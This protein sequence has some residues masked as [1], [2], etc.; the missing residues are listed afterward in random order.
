MLPFEKQVDPGRFRF[1]TV[2]SV[3]Y[4]Y[5]CRDVSPGDPC[6]LDRERSLRV[7]VTL[8]SEVVQRTT[9]FTSTT[10]VDH[11]DSTSNLTY[12]CLHFVSSGSSI[13]NLQPKETEV[14]NKCLIVVN[15]LGLHGRSM[16][17]V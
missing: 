9:W 3:P 5:L 15:A 2:L 8:P 12:Y 10:R 16:S 13:G 14:V 7:R 1:T 11:P 6:R 17:F 4:L